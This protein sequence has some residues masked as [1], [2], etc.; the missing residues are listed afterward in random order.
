[1]L[2]ASVGILKAREK[3]L[4]FIV[5]LWQGED[6]GLGFRCS[7][8]R[9]IFVEKFSIV[10]ADL[11]M[12]VINFELQLIMQFAVFLTTGSPSGT[13]GPMR[14]AT[15][16]RSTAISGVRGQLRMDGSSTNFQWRSTQLSGIRTPGECW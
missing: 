6:A 5:C 2:R 8:Y 15:W 13:N 14:T 12:Q 16:A 4:I 1:M 10:N 3:H 7:E 11:L 9:C